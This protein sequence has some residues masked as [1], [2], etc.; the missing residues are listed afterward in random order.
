[1]KIL[2]TLLSA[3]L[4]IALIPAA[5]AAGTPQGK[6]RNHAIASPSAGDG[7]TVSAPADEV[8]EYAVEHV[9][10]PLEPLNRGTFWVNDKLYAYLLRPASKVYRTVLPAKV[11]SSVFNVFD[12]LE[13]P[14]RF[15]NDSLQL[16]FR[17]A[18][19]ETGKFLVNSVGGV[20][21]LIRLS[22]R[23]PSLANVPAADTGQTFAKWGIGHGPYFVL[24]VLGPRSLRDTVGLAGDYALY[25][26][27]WISIYFSTYSW[28]LALSTPD[29]VRNLH[30]KITTYDALTHN[31]LD[32]YLAIR[33]AYYQHRKQVASQ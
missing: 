15:V 4:L 20:G 14:I 18:G 7:K 19:Q 8:D 28:T 6:S 12:N 17:R 32:P 21:G 5:S 2:S 11:R 29:T 22:D 27:T 30:E 26:V 16:N 31:T 25:P 10:D 13:F 3:L 33:S 24:P 1:M 9:D 23:V